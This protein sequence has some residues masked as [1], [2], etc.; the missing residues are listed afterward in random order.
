MRQ[1]RHRP[2]LHVSWL[3]A[4]LSAAFLA[5]IAAAYWVAPHLR[6][7]LWLLFVVLPLIGAGFS[8]RVRVVGLTLIIAAD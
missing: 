4:W 1:V 2:R 6:G 5:G 8:T 7:D 3:L